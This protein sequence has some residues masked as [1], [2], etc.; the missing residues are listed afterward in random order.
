MNSEELV[1]LALEQGFSNAALVETKD[2][3]FVP[4]FRICCEDNTCGKYGANYSCPPDCG[5][6]Q[7]MEAQAKAHKYALVLQTMWDIDD[8]QDSA[9]IQTAKAKH[10]RMI[11]QLIDQLRPV[12]RGIMAGASG[13]NLCKECAIVEGQPCRF[14]DRKFSCM[15]AYCIYVEKLAEDHG[16]EYDSGPGIVNFFGMYL[17]DWVE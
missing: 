9:A 1:A 3:P 12:S 11:A 15:S 2:I 4:G 6:P 5:S 17:F 16:M 13:C 10:N 7:A 14:P 8:P